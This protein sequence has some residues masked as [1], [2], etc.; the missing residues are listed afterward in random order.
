[1]TSIGAF[2]GGQLGA[3]LDPYLQRA[4]GASSSAVQNHVP[5]D[6]LPSG[7]TAAVDALSDAI[8]A[9]IQSRS[10]AGMPY[11]N[12]VTEAFAPLMG[13]IPIAFVD[14]RDMSSGPALNDMPIHIPLSA[15]RWLE[16]ASERQ[17][18]VGTP[19]FR[20]RS[21][22]KNTAPGFAT[23]ASPVKVNQMQ[24]RLNELERT[25][26]F[27]G[28]ADVIDDPRRVRPR[29]AH[30]AHAHSAAPRYYQ[31]APH[32]TTTAVDSSQLATHRYYGSLTAQGLFSKLAYL[33]PVLQIGT[34][35]NG[36][37]SVE[38]RMADHTGEIALTYG[39]GTRGHL[40]NMF[41]CEPQLGEQFYFTLGKYERDDLL[42]VGCAP[43]FEYTTSTYGKRCYD[44]INVQRP[45]YI[46]MT[47]S[48]ALL[49]LRGCS[50]RDGGQWLGKSSPL[51]TMKP[52]VADRFYVEREKR[53]AVEWREFDFDERGMPRV[54]STLAEGLQEAVA[55]LPDLVLEHYLESV[56][57]YSVGNVKSRLATP[58]TSTAI[59]NAH[60]DATCLNA[61]PRVEMY[62]N[63]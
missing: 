26:Q 56:A 32:D 52:N 38:A 48:S 53:A 44:Q 16:D 2:V 39:V 31:S 34:Q 20:Y 37:H 55:N 21:D 18:T 25:V 28:T 17:L 61:Q 41:S 45:T 27:Y 7:P 24:L 54:R 60:Y 9:N 30:D 35:Y 23:L 19:L 43:R 6:R 14:T 36:S 33:G 3:V 49:Q 47:D 8:M 5:V 10:T 46:G 51:D 4:Q 42:T 63:Y 57:I 59:L 13:G 50:S 12:D 62:L 29:S 22:L 58:T 1:M 40:A 11:Q 15:S